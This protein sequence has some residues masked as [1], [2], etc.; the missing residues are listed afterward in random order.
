MN[1]LLLNQIENSEEETASIEE[2]NL[3][4]NQLQLLIEPFFLSCLKRPDINIMK[5]RDS[6][7]EIEF[8]LHILEDGSIDPQ[9]IKLLININSKIISLND[10]EIENIVEKGLYNSQSNELSIKLKSNKIPI[11][12]DENL[13]NIIETFILSLSKKCNFSTLNKTILNLLRE[14]DFTFSYY[15]SNFANEDIPILNKSNIKL[16]KKDFTEVD[17]LIEREKN[18]ILNY[19]QNIKEKE[20]REILKRVA[21]EQWKKDN[22]REW[23]IEMTDHINR[24]LNCFDVLKT[25]HGK[26]AYLDTL[27]MHMEFLNSQK[28]PYE[29]IDNIELNETAYEISF[30]IPCN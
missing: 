12:E 20:K 26:N 22:P 21:R 4:K 2:L 24:R 30:Y 3:L 9:S 5:L 16:L 1:N 27:R 25:P 13:T 10:E 6:L 17:V 19:I 18:R 8:S 14:T 23:N 11:L 28:E 7:G 15:L 29:I